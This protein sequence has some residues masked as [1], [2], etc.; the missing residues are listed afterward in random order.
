[1]YDT[2]IDAYYDHNIKTVGPIGYERDGSSV[3][4]ATWGDYDLDCKV[5]YGSSPKEAKEELLQQLCD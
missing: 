1:M 2:H 4:Q 3:Y 5:G